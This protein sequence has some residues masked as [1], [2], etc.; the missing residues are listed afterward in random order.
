MTFLSDYDSIMTDPQADILGQK[1]VSTSTDPSN[2]HECAGYCSIVST[3]CLMYFFDT[4]SSTCYA[5]LMS[6]TGG[7]WSFTDTIVTKFHTG[8]YALY[9]FRE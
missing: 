6:H 9:I 7:S 1:V 4:G 2:E 8:N 3:D 5:A